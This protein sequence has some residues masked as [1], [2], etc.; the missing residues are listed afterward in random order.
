MRPKYTEGCFL[1]QPRRARSARTVQATALVRVAVLWSQM[2]ALNHHEVRTLQWKCILRYDGGL[3]FARE[4]RGV[5]IRLGHTLHLGFA[6]GRGRSALRYSAGAAL[7][8]LE[9]RVQLR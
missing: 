7:R 4:K 3:L 8:A 6:R 9:P 1:G 2:P 5:Q